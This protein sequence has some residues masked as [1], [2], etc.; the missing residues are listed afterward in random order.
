ISVVF[1]SAK[2]CPFAERKATLLD[3]CRLSLRERTSFRGA[4]GDTTRSLSS[5]APR[6]DVLSRSERRHYSI[7]VVFRSAK[8]RSIA[9]RKATLLDLCR[10]SLRERTF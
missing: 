8:G 3:L 2:E 6:K 1:R 7:S 9:E 4:K 5:F 10:L